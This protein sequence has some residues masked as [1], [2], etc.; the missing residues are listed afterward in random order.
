MELLRHEAVRMVDTY[1]R[2][3]MEGHGVVVWFVVALG[4]SLLVSSRQEGLIISA[5]T[6]LA[7]RRGMVVVCMV[8][9]PYHHTT[10]MVGVRWYGR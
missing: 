1:R 3:G 10:G 2:A 6:L 8:P 7:T 5:Y 9:L 4:G